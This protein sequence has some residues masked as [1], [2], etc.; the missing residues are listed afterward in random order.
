M[1]LIHTSTNT[2]VFP[3]ILKTALFKYRDT[4]FL[5]QS[6]SICVVSKT[7]I[8]LPSIRPTKCFLFKQNTS[9]GNKKNRPK[10]LVVHSQT[11]MRK[12]KLSKEEK[13][14][15]DMDTLDMDTI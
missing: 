1:V 11:R 10:S 8:G 14:S 5:L 6:H 15:V 3:C 13:G 9:I 4:S 12:E 2:A 7:S